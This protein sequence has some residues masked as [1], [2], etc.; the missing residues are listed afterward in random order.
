MNTRKENTNKTITKEIN[1][2]Y[3]NLCVQNGV[4]DRRLHK[5][6]NACKLKPLKGL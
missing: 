4:M 2:L 6:Y 1:N 3:F 5:I